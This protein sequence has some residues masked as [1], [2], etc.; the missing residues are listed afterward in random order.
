VVDHDFK[1][2]DGQ[3][4]V[5]PIDDKEIVLYGVDGG[6]FEWTLPSLWA[7]ASISATPV[8]ESAAAQHYIVGSDSKVQI[9]ARGRTAYILKR[10]N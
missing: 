1:S 2:V 3:R 4:R 9:S 8:N 5:I 6:P 7:R 10:L